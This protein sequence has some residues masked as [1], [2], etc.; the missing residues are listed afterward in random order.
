MS[1]RNPPAR[2]YKY[3][4]NS[5]NN[6]SFNSHIKDN[7][8]YS[9]FTSHQNNNKPALSQNNE[10]NV[11]LKSLE[12][13]SKYYYLDKSPNTNNT[14]FDSNLRKYRA[15]SSSANPSISNTFSKYGRTLN[16]TKYQEGKTY[17][18][19]EKNL[20]NPNRYVNNRMNQGQENIINQYKTIDNTKNQN[21]REF[22]NQNKSI[23]NKR[24][25]NYGKVPSIQS[26]ILEIENK[27]EDQRFNSNTYGINIQNINEQSGKKEEREKRIEVDQ[28]NQLNQY[29]YQNKRT[30]NIQENLYNNRNNN[31]IKSQENDNVKR[32]QLLNE[33]RAYRKEQNQYNV[34]NNQQINQEGTTQKRQQQNIINNYLDKKVY[35]EDE[36][37]TG[38]KE[39]NVEII[40]K[41]EEKTIVLLPGQTIEPKTITETFEN[42]FIETIENEDGSVS[43]ILKQ[44]KITT[45]TE[46]VQIGNDIIKSINGSPE[47]PLVKQYITYEYRTVS[48]LNNNKTEIN[49]QLKP[50]NKNLEKEKITNQY[51]MQN[52]FEDRPNKLYENEQYNNVYQGHNLEKEQ[53]NERKNENYLKSGEKDHKYEINED[54]RNNINVE[55]NNNNDGIQEINLNSSKKGGNILIQDN[56]NNYEQNGD[57]IHRPE[58]NMNSSSKKGENIMLKGEFRNNIDIQEINMISPIKGKNVMNKE[59]NIKPKNYRDIIEIQENS[60]ELSKKDINIEIKRSNIN[61]TEIEEENKELKELL[62]NSSKKE[63]NMDLKGSNIKSQVNENKKEKK[64]VNIKNDINKINQGNKLQ[65]GE[66]Y[67]NY[68]KNPYNQFKNEKLSVSKK[69]RSGK[70]ANKN[71]FKPSERYGEK[72]SKNK[73][74]EK[75]HASSKQENNKSVRKSDKT[76]EKYSYTEKKHKKVNKRFEKLRN[77]QKRD[78]DNINNIN[79]NNTYGSKIREGISLYEKNKKGD[80]T[81]SQ[82]KQKKLDYILN[83]YGQC[84]I[85]GN[86]SGS[87]NNFEKLVNIL[88]KKGEKDRKDILLK[89]KKNFPN[90][91]DLYKK[92]NAFIVKKNNQK[93]KG[94]LNDKKNIELSKN[95]NFIRSNDNIRIGKEQLKAR[96]EYSSSDTHKKNNKNVEIIDKNKLKFDRSVVDI[97]NYIKDKNPFQGISQYNKFYK[98]RKTQIKKSINIIGNEGI[99][100]NEIEGNQKIE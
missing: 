98:N 60:L 73:T 67:S 70:S 46:N 31:L 34:N 4:S 99:I 66:R 94:K 35:K 38:N 14:Y 62:Q 100:N 82:K 79:I 18:K 29:Q 86:K 50:Q 12:L 57:N 69:K 84:S 76:S 28:N 11:C 48:S 42:P 6:N 17:M 88:V 19:D 89:L 63:I 61:N 78:K 27:Y 49:Q 72:L 87:E 3:Q 52:K 59:S 83:L 65:I 74:T 40:K 9:T 56:I 21:E 45:I 91:E 51:G 68:E 39:P 10:T 55:M 32:Y 5:L 85:E 80:N 13:T 30:N 75:L 16:I 58:S 53:L 93:I 15:I 36:K 8:K 77:L 2:I 43:S 44:T 47:L 26:R 41:Y 97:S 22:L 54:N 20:S 90:N 64:N 1:V 37:Q 81:T 96:G 23:K 92:L 71:E 25:Q 24:I 95:S 7:S 33:K